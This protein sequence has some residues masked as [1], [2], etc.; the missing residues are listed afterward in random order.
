M[1]HIDGSME[2]PLEHTVKYSSDGQFVD[3]V[4]LEFA[5]YS[6]P[7]RKEYFKLKQ[8]ITSVFMAVQKFSEGRKDVAE[9]KEQKA[10]SDKT[11]AEQSADANDL[12]DLVSFGMS[13]D[14][15]IDIEEFVETF[16]AMVCNARKPLCKIDGKT[17]I[18]AET[19]D[20]MHPDDQLNAAVRYCCF[21]GIGLGKIIGDGRNTAT[22]S[23]TQVKAL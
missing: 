6:G 15:T 1:S 16:K 10:L 12:F 13:L 5:E 22:T 9:A 21:F 19:W 18:R 7:H 11:D 3:A 8:T 23:H 20:G 4:F 14:A 2:Y 17:N